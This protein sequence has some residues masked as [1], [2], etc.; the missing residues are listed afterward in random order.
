MIRL[1]SFLLVPIL[2]A[3][4]A[5]APS[6][7]G[8]RPSP[9]PEL[10]GFEQRFK[11]K[12]A[13][14]R[15]ALGRTGWSLYFDGRSW[16]VKEIRPERIDFVIRRFVHTHAFFRKESVPESELPTTT[17][18]EF[19]MDAPRLTESRRIAVN[20]HVVVLFRL[21]GRIG[22]RETVLLNYGWS[23]PA[24]TVVVTGSALRKLLSRDAEVEITEFLNGLV[25]DDA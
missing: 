9:Y 17:A 7:K 1:S 25:A 23:G 3:L 12:N 20:G 5:C 8:S 22:K 18:R 11:S 14:T 2:L 4:A 21:E 10:H 16:S 13:Q 6:V 15:V 19:G 24:G